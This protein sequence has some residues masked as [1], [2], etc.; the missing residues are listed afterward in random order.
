MSNVAK[1]IEVSAASAKGLEDA[2]K[3]G[4][5][6]VARTVGNIRGA[7]VSEVKVRT[8]PDGSIREWRVCMR[9]SFV[10]E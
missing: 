6:K 1:G 9:V 7:W 2:V 8:S 3:T 10:V 4:L 5:E